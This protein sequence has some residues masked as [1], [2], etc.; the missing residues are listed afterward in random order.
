MLPMESGPGMSEIDVGICMLER[1]SLPE[2]GD[3]SSREW[4]CSSSPSRS[5]SLKS[6]GSPSWRGSCVRR[7]LEIQG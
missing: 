2:S 6:S 3:S 5:S 7:C 4:R 1:Y